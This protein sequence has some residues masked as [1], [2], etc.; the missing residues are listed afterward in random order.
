M[1]KELAI[2]TVIGRDQIG[3]VAHVSRVLYEN[4]INIEDMSQSIM[5]GFFVMGMLVDVGRSPKN[6]TCLFLCW[7][8]RMAPLPNAMVR[9]LTGKSHVFRVVIPS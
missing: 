2:I 3:I 5:E 8:I 9:F 7:R 6:I 4:Q 1:K